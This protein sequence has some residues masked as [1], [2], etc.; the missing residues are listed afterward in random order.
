MVWEDA[1]LI[2]TCR[3]ARDGGPGG[4]APPI[5]TRE[6]YRLGADGR[7]IVDLTWRRGTQEV[8][9]TFSYRKAEER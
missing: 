9:R 3:T 4:M 2:A 1:T 7:L 5:E 8:R 6:V